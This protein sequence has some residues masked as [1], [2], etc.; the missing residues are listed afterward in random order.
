MT[1]EAERKALASGLA[2]LLGVEFDRADQAIVAEYERP[3]PAR[4]NLVSVL[5]SA[6][7]LAA[8]LR[9]MPNGERDAWLSSRQN[10]GRLRLDRI[11]GGEIASAAGDLADHLAG[12]Y[13]FILTGIGQK[14]WHGDVSVAECR[15][16]PDRATSL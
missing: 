14:W 13:A 11:L 1:I 6:A 12:P 4:R 9:S 7:Q 3:I 10:D 2:P 16:R 5:A 8:L 15:A